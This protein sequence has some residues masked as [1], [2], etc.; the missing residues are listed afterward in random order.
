MARLFSRFKSHRNSVKQP[1]K[2]DV[3]RWKDALK[4]DLW[5]AVLTAAKSTSSDE[6]ERLNFLVVLIKMAFICNMNI[7]Y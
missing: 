2:E 3:L 5:N 1:E 4:D 7:Q 6:I